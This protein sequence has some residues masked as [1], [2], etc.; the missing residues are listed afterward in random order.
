MVSCHLFEGRITLRFISR[1]KSLGVYFRGQ[2]S[3]GVHS[4]LRSQPAMIHSACKWSKCLPC[5][6]QE[7]PLLCSRCQVDT[8]VFSPYHE[9][10]VDYTHRD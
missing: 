8:T 3:S 10:P 5:V 4:L 9:E 7:I 1:E 6:R 2:N